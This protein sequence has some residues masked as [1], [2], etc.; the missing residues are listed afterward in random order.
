MTTEID[1]FS[2][3]V[4]LIY[5]AGLDPEMWPH[6]LQSMCR[7]V[8]A[9][10]AQILYIDPEDLYFSFACGYGFNP[11]TYDIG[12]SR[13][14]RYMQSDPVA[15]YGIQH[16][17]QA[18]ADRRV[19]DET[20]IKQSPAQR[21][22]RDPANM[23]FLLTAFLSDND[24]EWTGICFMRGKESEAFNL[25]DEITLNRFIPHIKRASF[26]HK[27]LASSSHLK[28]LQSSVLDNIEQGIIVVDE[29]HDV[30]ATNKKADDILDQN[31]HLYI[32]RK[33]LVC[34]DKQVGTLLFQ[35]IGESLDNQ[36]KNNRSRT[37]VRIQHGSGRSTFLVTTPL[38]LQRFKESQQK[39]PDSTHYYT[40]R[41]PVKNHALI[42][43]CEVDSAPKASVNIL[44]D[45]FGLTPAEAALAVALSSGDSLQQAA[46]TLGRT[47]GTARIQLQSIF[48]K[49]D[50]NRQANLIRLLMAIP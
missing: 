3:T 14:R 27:S 34:A 35:N 46:K 13:F 28:T 26:M 15:L 6:A 8:N 17:N 41:I 30:V 12:A 16:M 44:M 7:H 4:S 23:E 5:E 19:I 50:T 42:T 38:Q 24:M 49:T 18:F 43:L 45:L 20:V 22:I 32:K 37:A 2:E 21:E 9:S 48:E 31:K 11:Y 39:L 29:L 10:K 36:Q 33:R 25:N 1:D 47:S 40:A